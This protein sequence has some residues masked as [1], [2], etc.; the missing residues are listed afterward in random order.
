VDAQAEHLTSGS[1]ALRLL[2]VFL[3]VLLNGFFV[4]AEFALVSVRRSRLEALEAK[5]D[6]TARVIRETLDRINHYISAAQLGITV[7]SLA[8]GWIGE[9]A[10]A[11]IVDGVLGSF[12][13]GSPSAVDHT[14]AAAVTAFLVLMFLH[15]VMGEQAPKA[16]AI[17]T[18]ERLS[19]IVVRPLRW[20]AKLTYPFTWFLNASSNALVRLLGFRPVEEMEHVHSA[21]ELMLLVTQAYKHGQLDQSDRDMLAGV[22]DLHKKKIRDVM[23]PRTEVVALS[24]DA[25]ETE[26]R[27]TLRRERYSRYPVYKDSLDDVVGVFIGKDYMFYDGDAPFSLASVVREGL[28]VPDSRPAERV[29][30]DLR[31][32]RAHMAIV[33]DEYGGTAGMVTMEDLV[34]E[35]IGEIADEYDLATRSSMMSDGVLELAGSMSLIDVRSDHNIPIPQGSWSTLG[36]YVFSRLGR[37]PRIGD[38]VK[39]PGGELEVVAMDGRR[40]AAVR[41]HRTPA[42]AGTAA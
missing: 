35:V 30:D 20:W 33:L 7:A 9:A 13:I 6:R 37:L 25:T 29:I 32:T 10:L 39:F 12:G 36:G 5:G 1:I 38:R 26:V 28:F 41:V 11:T 3:L 2:A 21:E 34:E 27:D 14:V 24:I 31:K 23:R 42:G 16:M 22:F 40:V 8:L 19:R 18:P 17:M 4:A 15:I